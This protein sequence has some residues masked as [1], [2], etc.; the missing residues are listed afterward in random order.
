MVNATTL[1]DCGSDKQTTAT[2]CTSGHLYS[3]LLRRQ[4]Q[5]AEQKRKRRQGQKQKRNRR[6]GRC[7]WG[8]AR[9]RKRKRRLGRCRL[10]GSGRGTTRPPPPGP[11]PASLHAAPPAAR[12]SPLGCATGQYGP[13][14]PGGGLGRG[15]GGAAAAVVRSRHRQ[16]PPAHC[17]PRRARGAPPALAL[18]CR[19][20]AVSRLW[21]A[22]VGSIGLPPK[23]SNMP[24]GT[25]LHK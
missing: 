7:P 12:P 6:L 23:G 8:R 25:D 17:C 24:R 20:P 11:A 3:T 19:A 18:W 5:K 13:R 1:S 9:K 14:T 4:G 16:A 10:Q 2:K 21:R 22:S 15:G